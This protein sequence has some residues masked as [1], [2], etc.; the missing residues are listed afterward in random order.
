M[1]VRIPLREEEVSRIRSE[2]PSHGRSRGRME[3]VDEYFTPPHKD[4]M[5]PEHPFEWL[6]IRRRGGKAL[7]NYKRFHSDRPGEFTHCDEV[8]TEVGD[9]ESLK[10]TF[11]ALGFR[12]LVTVEKERETFLVGDEFEVALDAVKELGHFIEIEALKDF[13]GAKEARKKVIAF[14]KRLGL[15]V[16]QESKRGYAYLVAKKIDAS[17]QGK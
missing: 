5:E 4:F 12:P 2:M 9:A 6:S 1:E 16:S 10:K 11:S 3:Q 17:R 14:A 15:D 13:G 8:E 7:L